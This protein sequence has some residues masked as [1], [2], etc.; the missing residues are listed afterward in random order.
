MESYFDLMRK[1]RVQLIDF[2][3]SMAFTE[4]EL[5]AEIIS[6]DS[7]M[8]RQLI[9]VEAG[10][11]I[12]AKD[13]SKYQIL[14]LRQA[15]ELKREMQNNPLFVYQMTVNKLNHYKGI[16]SGTYE[17]ALYICGITE[18]DIKSAKMRAAVERAISYVTK[19]AC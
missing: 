12:R 17:A 14:I 1:H 9:P 11:F 3:K 18:D 2:L 16:F 13:I 4:K 10:D 7:Q 15:I 19:R 5:N 6:I 8:R